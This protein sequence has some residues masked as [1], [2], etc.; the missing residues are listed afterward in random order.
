[1]KLKKKF[2]KKNFSLFIKIWQVLERKRKK[3]IYLVLILMFFAA[4]SEMLSLATFIPVL[5]SISNTGEYVKGH[6]G[7]GVIITFL[8]NTIGL[9][10]LLLI[11][12]IVF[13]LTISITALI[14]IFNIWTCGRISAAICL[15]VSKIAYKK[16]L[17]QPYIDLIAEGKSYYLN[18]LLYQ[19]SEVAS[20]V[21]TLLALVTNLIVVVLLV[22]IL[23]FIDIKVS[24]IS[25]ILIGLFYFLL[26]QKVRKVLY[27]TGKKI[28]KFQKEKINIFQEDL[29]AVKDIIM[30]NNQENSVNSF[31]EVESPLRRLIIKNEFL[32]FFPRYVLEAV[33]LSG[34]LS[35]TFLIVSLRSGTATIVPVLGSIALGIL[36]I[37]PSIQV[38]FASLG[39][40]QVKIPGL[41]LLIKLLDKKIP[42]VS[43]FKKFE[44]FNFKNYIQLNKICFKYENG[45]KDVLK[46]I[47]LTIKKGEIV[48]ISGKNGSGKS[49]LVDLIMG[50]LKPNS[51]EIIIDDINITHGLKSQFIN[52]WR[53]SISY[54]SQSIYLQ[55]K[56]IL[57][58]IAFGI[59]KKDIDYNQLAKVSE[60]AAIDQ[61]IKELPDLYDTKVGEGGSKLSGGQ[62]QRIAIARALYLKSEILILDEVTNNLDYKSSKNIIEII[63]KL[64]NKITILIISHKKEILEVCDSIYQLHEN[65][66]EPFKFKKKV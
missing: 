17:Y 15:D 25:F 34:M 58:N 3:Q 49:T 42:E 8:S 24:I 9:D 26:I 10:N 45:G 27:K 66:L 60:Q 37:M 16:V 46:E 41:N 62:K 2:F 4:I 23:L 44:K 59:D 40:I 5:T 12:T 64:K 50:L 11:S 1:M 19:L 51:G 39:N 65:K 48:G 18:L 7:L 61:F 36:K 53:N 47:D 6:Y 32:I 38:I 30:T 14:R 29:G 43:E 13:I 21:N 33:V 35:M 52:R 63:Y 28:T 56:S 31:L 22:S 54:V 55:D 57:E 20:L